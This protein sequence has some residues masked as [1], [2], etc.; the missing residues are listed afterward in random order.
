MLVIVLSTVGIPAEGIALIMGIERPLDMMRTVANI[1]GDAMVAT[2]VASSENEIGI[3]DEDE[4]PDDS[5]D[6]P[7][8]PKAD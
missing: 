7:S 6:L 2:V 5:G 1:T 3:T 4:L 8:I